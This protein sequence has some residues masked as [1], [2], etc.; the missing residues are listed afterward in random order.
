MVTRAA[1][2]A[3]AKVPLGQT[4]E[5]EEASDI[6]LHCKVIQFLQAAV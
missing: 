3:I 6:H 4:V 5:P 1:A 2:A